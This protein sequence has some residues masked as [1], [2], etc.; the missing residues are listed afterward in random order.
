MDP[1]LT[2]RLRMRFQTLD[3]NSNGYLE[4]GDFESEVD[5]IVAATGAP[6]DSPRAQL[7]RE[8]YRTYWW[9]ILDRLDRDGDGRIDFDEYAQI[10]HSIGE[11]KPFAHAR[12]KAVDRFTDLNAD[13]WIEKA[14]YMT[15]MLAARFDEA[16]ASAA[17]DALGPDENGRIRAG[18]YADLIMEF[19][20]RI[21]DAEAAQRLV[22]AR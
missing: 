14:D 3:G 7:L 12:A 11:F 20:D 19:Y 1:E 9:A 6:G 18:R 22:P 16:A 8:A 15:V 10:V 4:G 5:R 17:Y 2:E 21:A 13:G